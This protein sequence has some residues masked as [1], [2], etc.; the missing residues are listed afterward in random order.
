MEVI[1]FVIERKC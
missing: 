1:L